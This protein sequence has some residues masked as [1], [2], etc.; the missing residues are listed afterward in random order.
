MVFGAD[1]FAF[2]SF[3]RGG[4]SRKIRSAGWSSRR[5]G[6]LLEHENALENCDRRAPVALPKSCELAVQVDSKVWRLQLPT[7][8]HYIDAGR[9]RDIDFWTLGEKL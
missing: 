5:R 1:F 3:E 2:F 7:M 8:P 4:A 9:S 6:V